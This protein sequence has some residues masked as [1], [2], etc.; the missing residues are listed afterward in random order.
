VRAVLSRPDIAPEGGVSIEPFHDD[1]II[2]KRTPDAF[3]DTA[4]YNE[5][6]AAR[7]TTLVIAGTQ[8]DFCIDT[9]CRRAFSLGFNTVLI[10]DGHSTWDSK[11]LTAQQII[12]HHNRILAA[13]FVR[14]L[15]AAEL[16]FGQT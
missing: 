11:W 13:H 2:D 9:T 5:L 14:L 6:K 10:N 12:R 15:S 7:I 3:H 16:D 1:R 8:T 4:L